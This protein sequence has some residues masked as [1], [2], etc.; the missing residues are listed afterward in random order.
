MK[1]YVTGGC[2]FLGSN[3]CKE[4]VERG[5]SVFCLDNLVTGSKINI[6]ELSKNNS[7]FYFINGLA[8]EIPLNIKVDGIFHLASPAA[9]ADIQKYSELAFRS[10]SD[11]TEKLALW[12]K[13]QESKFLFVSTMKIHGD[14]ER[15]DSYIRGKREGEIISSVNVSKIARLASVY[16][17]NMRL[18]DSRVIPVFITKALKGEPLSLWNGGSQIDSFC[19]VT[20]IVKALIDFM[21]SDHTGVIELGNPDGI[22]IINLALKI[23]GL[24]GKEV[25]LNTN[26]RVNVVE[27]CHNLPDLS[28]AKECLE[29][30]PRVSLDEGLKRT[31]DDFKKRM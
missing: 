21:E 28:R 30:F 19:Y 8:D 27:Q 14:C 2:G 12:S 1:Y 24:A 13:E 10:N 31:I 16:G 17:P 3:L 18:D 20:D 29:W 26:E 23:I 7:N 25:T 15:V 11:T 9:P 6:E 22:S 5:H 4:L